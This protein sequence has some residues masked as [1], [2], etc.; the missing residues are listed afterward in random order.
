M[1]QSKHALNL[2]GYIFAEGC[3]DSKKSM[4]NLLVQKYIVPKSNAMFK[5]QVFIW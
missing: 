1:G 5:E 4:A 2:H 3:R